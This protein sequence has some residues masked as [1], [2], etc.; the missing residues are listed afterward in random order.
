MIP[1]HSLKSEIGQK[2]Q[3]W[4]LCNVIDGPTD[5]WLHWDPS[6]LVDIRMIETYEEINGSTVYTRNCKVKIIISLSNYMDLLINQGQPENQ[7][8]EKLYYVRDEQWTKLRAKD[9]RTAWV[10]AKSEQKSSSRTL[11]PSF[12]TAP[13]TAHIRSPMTME[14][15]S[16]TKKHQ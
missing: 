12:N 2:L 10:N 8:D 11:M 6:V 1:G 7:L 16:F 9:M 5:F 14:L 3:K 4:V 13:S 15:A